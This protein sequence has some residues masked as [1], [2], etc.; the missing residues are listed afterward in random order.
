MTEGWYWSSTVSYSG[1]SC[2]YLVGMSD[3]YANCSSGN[4]G[5]VRPVFVEGNF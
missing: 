1:G 5:Y 4:F 3:G 2:Y